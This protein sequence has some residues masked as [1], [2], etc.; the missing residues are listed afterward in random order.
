MPPLFSRALVAFSRF[1]SLGVFF[2]CRSRFVLF[3]VFSP[4]HRAH[5]A[6][7]AHCSHRAHCPRRPPRKAHRVSRHHRAKRGGKRDTASRR[8]S[9]LRGSNPL[10]AFRGVAPLSRRGSVDR[11]TFRPTARAPSGQA[12]LRG[13]V[14]SI[15]SL[16]ARRRGRRRDRAVSRRSFLD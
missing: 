1:A 8:G 7:R 9:P 12:P 3:F 15:E 2:S 11:V 6:H 4:P 10:A 16:F 13:A 5:R 14:L